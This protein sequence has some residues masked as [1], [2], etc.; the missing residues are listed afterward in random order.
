VTADPRGRFRF[1]GLP[2]G[3][4]G[5]SLTGSAQTLTRA[6]LGVD[7]ESTLTVGFALATPSAAPLP[8]RAVLQGIAP[9]QAG[10]SAIVTNAGGLSTA[11]RIDEDATFRFEGLAPGVYQLVAGD[12]QMAGLEVWADEILQITFPPPAAHWQVHVRSRAALRRPGLV[13][14]LVVGQS[15]VAVTLA[16][17]SVGELVRPT[18]SAVDYGPFAVE[19]G[20]LE[21]GSYTV[22]VAGIDDRAAFTLDNTDAVVVTFQR[23][24]ALGGPPRLEYRPL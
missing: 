11:C 18:G 9:G 13:R 6:R 4:Y 21:P 24:G 12:L 14:V 17:E 1:S 7:G 10:R 23:G 19:F 15:G 2:P 16:G 8:V 5:I 20:P 22:A 3:S